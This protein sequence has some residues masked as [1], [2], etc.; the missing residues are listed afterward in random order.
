[1]S[2]YVASG[3]RYRERVTLTPPSGPGRFALD[4]PASCNAWAHQ[5]G[6]C[7]TE[8]GARPEIDRLD[9]FLACPVE[10]AVAIGWWANAVGPTEILNW[11]GKTG[12]YVPMW[13]LP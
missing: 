8:L 13:H 5:I 6:N 7:L 2:A 1:V 11:A 10:L 4:G 3:H 9:L 12:P